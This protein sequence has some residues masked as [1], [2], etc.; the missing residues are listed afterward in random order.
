[1]IVALAPGTWSATDPLYAPDS[2]WC[3]WLETQGITVRVLTWTT[4]LGGFGPSRHDTWDRAATYWAAGQAKD[5]VDAWLVHSHA[6]Q[7]AAMAVARGAVVP[8]LVTV[9]T[10]VRHDLQPI[11]QAARVHLDAQGGTWRHLF[12][13]ARR[14]VWGQFGALFDGGLSVN[15]AMAQAH[16]NVY[17]PARGHAVGEWFDP[18][19]WDP[20]WLRP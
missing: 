9:C 5:P 12:G 6:G 1:M 16:A 20:R 11:Y 15:R 4:A 19:T 14:D 8:L 13:G 3:R 7:P 2:L 17:C 18:A 10:P